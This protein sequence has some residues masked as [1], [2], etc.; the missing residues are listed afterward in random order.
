MP[1]SALA[2]HFKDCV[3]NTGLGFVQPMFFIGVVEDRNDPR[4]EG[5]VRVRAFGVHGSN[6]DIPT[7]E[8]PWATL[9]IGSHDVNFTIPPLNVWVFGFFIDGRDAQQP[10][11]LGLIP[12]QASSVVNP[13]EVGWGAQPSENYELQMQGARARDVG[14]SPM[15]NLATG[16]FLNE[17]YNAALEVNRTRNIPI[18]GGGARNYS[19][20]G[21]G[22]SWSDDRDEAS[23]IGTTSSIG[24]PGPGLTPDRQREL[25]EFA[26][27]NGINPNALAGVLNIE[28]GFDPNRRGGAGNNFYGIFQ[29]QGSQIPTLTQSALGRNL[30]PSQYRNL[31][32]GD[33]LKV[34]QQYINQWIP[35]TRSFFTGDANQDAARLWAIQLAPANA[36]RINYSDSNATIS[37][38]NQAAAISARRGL[39]T[40]G[41]V[42]TGTLQRG[43]L[44]P[45]S[46]NDSFTESDTN[47]RQSNQNKAQEIRE[48]I[49]AIDREI[50][51]LES[52]IRPPEEARQ[53]IQELR[54]ERLR[55]EQELAELDPVAS[56]DT[57]A[58]EPYRGYMNETAPSAVSSW[59]EP[60][61]AYA[62]QYPFN[63][64]IETAAGHSIEIDDSPGGERIMIWHRNGSYI[65]IS[66]T[67]T[68]H[69]NMGD[70]YNVHERNHHVYIKGTNIITIEGDSH[71][72]VKGNKVE[73]IQGDYRQIVH[74]SIQIGAARSVEINGATRTD[75]RSASL[76]LDSNVENLNIRTAQTIAFESGNSISFNSKNISMSASENAS[77]TGQGVFVESKQNMHMKAN[78]NMFVNPSQN[79]FLRADG[80]TIS[81]QTGGSIRMNSGSFMSMKSNS[82]FDI[83]AKS[84]LV[85]KS[86]ATINLNADGLA[87]IKSEEMF[88]DSGSGNLNLRSGAEMRIRGEGKLSVKGQDVVVEGEGAVDVKGSGGPISLD[89]SGA[90]NLLSGSQTRI[91]GSDVYI[92]GGTTY[93]DDIV[94]LASGTNNPAAPADEA[95]NVDVKEQIDPAAYGDEFSDGDIS[96]SADSAPE[97]P[98]GATPRS[99]ATGPAAPPQDSIPANELFVETRGLP[100]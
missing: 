60:A 8:L 53:R 90:M 41:S 11:I 88:L 66:S 18:A 79:L 91:T 67:A 40:V 59:E 92:R 29:L 5:R 24:T 1:D 16:E 3:M 47:Q 43:G 34:Y 52:G 6:R 31:S 42:Q 51:V 45:T 7:D 25:L 4:F 98:V 74:G 96:P 81:M 84:N 49:E 50:A 10:M 86:D 48:R 36:R 85:V 19:P 72:L 20:G 73:E 32:F 35:N 77:I 61:S 27:R 100:Q 62:A 56:T 22:N 80:G 76:A 26:A 12:A 15:P 87:S 83:Q 39:V 21:N 69:K 63:R 99:S 97:A 58:G 44:Q 2:Q 70:S 78:G 14:T 9:I 71:V 82:T 93:I 65:Q 68:T 55:L 37:A 30:T 33:Q 28:S 54:E 13:S 75:I 94:Q 17:T 38:T 23:E 57:Q 89:A 95:T 46:S 64:V